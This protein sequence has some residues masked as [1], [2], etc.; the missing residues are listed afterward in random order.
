ML[1]L[2]LFLEKDVK[3]SIVFLTSRENDVI[4]N[5]RLGRIQYKY[6]YNITIQYKSSKY[7]F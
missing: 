2:A 4:F 5:I 6:I 1:F 7:F 3:F